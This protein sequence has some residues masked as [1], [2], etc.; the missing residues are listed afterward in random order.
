MYFE[1][2]DKAK[3]WIDRVQ[4]VHGRPHR[5]RR[6]DLRGAAEGRLA[7]ES[8]PGRRRPEGQGQGG[9]PVE[10]VHAAV[11]RASRTS[12]TPSSSK[13]RASPISN[14]RR[15]PRSW[16]ASASRSEVFNCSAPDT[17]N[18][19]VLE[20]YGTRAQ[21]DKWLKPL[22]NGE[23]RSAFLMTEPAVA[24]SDATNIQC[25]IRRDGERLRHQR[26]QMVVVRRRRSA[27]QG[28]DPDGQDQSR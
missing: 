2:S 19:E 9:G 25:E 11:E 23:I 26:P 18:M 16:A 4:Q 14:T 8:D 28:R 7:L 17:G 24:S 1:H 5:P 20:R 22:M 15:W 13:A 27:L 6:A 21:K 10:Y 3:A 12:M